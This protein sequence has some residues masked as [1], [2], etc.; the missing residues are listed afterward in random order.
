MSSTSTFKHRDHPA[1][2][3]VG[4]L[5]NDVRLDF[6]DGKGTLGEVADRIIEAV[7]HPEPKPDLQNIRISD[8]MFLRPEPKTRPLTDEEEIQYAAEGHAVPEVRVETSHE[9][10]YGRGNQGPGT[11]PD[12]ERLI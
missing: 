3:R 11:G 6:G 12:G 8:D 4:Q 2:G 5:V 7:L 1:W 9:Y 10:P